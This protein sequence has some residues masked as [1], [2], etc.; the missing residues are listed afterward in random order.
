MGYKPKKR[1]FVLK[2][3]DEEYEGMEVRMRSISVEKT[4]ELMSQADK[5][6]S[7]EH[8]R[9]DG[10]RE[11]EKLFGDFAKNLESW[12]LENDDD[13]PIP[14]DLEGVK[15]LDLDFFMD[16]LFGWLEGMLSVSAPLGRRSSD[17]KQSEELS[18]PMETL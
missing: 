4:M 5:A 7:G 14:A 15:Q 16:L 6:R 10:A 2:F 12:N 11:M 17:G 3:E 1:T 9:G 8:E 18:I 13:A